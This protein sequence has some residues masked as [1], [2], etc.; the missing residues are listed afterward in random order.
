M[1]YFFVYRSVGEVNFI[2]VGEK[3]KYLIQNVCIF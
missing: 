2:F 1:T 3:T